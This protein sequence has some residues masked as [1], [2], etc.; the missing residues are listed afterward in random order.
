[1]NDD[2]FYDLY[3][4]HHS[5]N[6]LWMKMLPLFI[7]VQEHHLN[8]TVFNEVADP[9][10]TAMRWTVDRAAQHIIRRIDSIPED[11]LYFDWMPSFYGE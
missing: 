9:I 8:V 11:L 3:L 10:A 2:D 6:I 1:M 4:D 5:R 7:I